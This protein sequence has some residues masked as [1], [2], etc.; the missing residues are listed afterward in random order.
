[1]GARASRRDAGASRKPSRFP[2]GFPVRGK[3]RIVLRALLG[4]QRTPDAELKAELTRYLGE[5]EARAEHEE[6]VDVHL[7]RQ[8]TECAMNLLNA[9]A[10]ETSEELRGLV[11][12]AIRYLLLEEDGDHDT[13]SPVGFDDDR[14]VLNAVAR[15]LGRNDLCV[16]AK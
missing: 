12:A 1:M 9:L 10:P 7:A 2:P 16:E 13:S 6:F 3:S 5:V 14:D 4:A 8:L 11:H 15:Q